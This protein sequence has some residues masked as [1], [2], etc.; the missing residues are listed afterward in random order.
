MRKLINYNPFENLKDKEVQYWLGWLASDGCVTGNRIIIS[1][2]RQD[3]DVL[4][5]FC[6][7][8]KNKISIFDGIYHKYKDFEYSRVSFR[9]TNT[10]NFLNSIG[11]TSNKSKTLKINIPLNWDFVRGFFEGDGHFGIHQNR[12]RIQFTCASKEFINQLKDFLSSNDI[13]SVITKIDRKNSSYYSLS[14]NRKKDAI[15]FMDNIYLTASIFMNRKYY[16]ARAIRNN[17]WKAVKLGEP[18]VGIPS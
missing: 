1:L 8:L 4:E 15:L 9:D 2:Q 14:I 13:F 12:P 11:I 16:N 5:K 7:F 6:L 18:A 17:G 10:V 3:R